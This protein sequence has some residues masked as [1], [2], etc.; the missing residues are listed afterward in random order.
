MTAELVIEATGEVITA[1]T[2]TEARDITRRI[3]SDLDG[4]ASHYESVMPLIREALTRQAW[5]ALGYNGPSDYIAAEFDGSMRGLPREVRQVVVAELSAAGMST[6]AIAPVVGVDQATVTRDRARG[7]ASASPEQS[8][9]PEPFPEAETENPLDGWSTSATEA[10]TKTTVT[11][12]TA[13]E[14]ITPVVGID[15]RRYPQ[16][17]KTAEPRRSPLADSARTAGNDIRKSAER[18]QR[19]IGDDRFTANK[20]QVAAHLRGHLLFA[21]DALQDALDRLSTN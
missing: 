4:I 3:N 2:E 7:D 20:E 1:M 13:T 9:S 18:I 21:I 11:T 16:R 5:A 17:P 8:C 15:G 6:R 10:L 12:K 14:P 19:V